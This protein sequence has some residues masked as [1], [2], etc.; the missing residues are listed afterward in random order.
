VSVK[1]VVWDL[2][3]TLWQGT[4]LEDGEVHLR[5]EVP[6]LLQELDRRGIL[7]SLAS[8][9]DPA[10]A[11]NRLT[12]LGIADYFLYPQI[13]WNPKS[14]ALRSI[15]TSLN[16]ALESFAFLD[17]QPFERAEVSHELPEVLC[18]DG[19]DLS[20]L[21]D[22]PQMHPRF[23]TSESASR[24]QLY[25]TDLLRLQAEAEFTGNN[26]DFLSTLEMNF[27][28][29]AA[30]ESDL[31]RAEELTVRTHQLNTTGDTYSYDELNELRLSPNHR[32]LVA[33][34]SD[35][36][37][38]YGTIGLALVECGRE[39]WTL[40][41]LLM[42]CRVM[43]RGVGSLLLHQVM[44]MA[45]AQGLPLRAEFVSN[46][47]NRMMYVTYKFAGFR[48]ISKQGDRSVLEHSLA[49]IPPVPTHLRLQLGDL[50]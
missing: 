10:S 37:G 8:K 18:L 35:R 27:R 38:S 12:E 47:K 49:E 48:E 9:N 25:Q 50:V 7:C 16:L 6:G 17:D 21:L 29:Q 44:R 43:S 39:F 34:L 1:C 45:R 2:D 46:G 14:A 28:I 31:Q 11:W 36:F 13:G 33:S 20:G 22:L 23:V 42:S 32:L 24:R 30:Q 19:S 41:L 5:P 26:E 15:A 3:N 40:K 4:L